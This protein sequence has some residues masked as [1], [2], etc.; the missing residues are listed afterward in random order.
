MMRL[1]G[2]RTSATTYANKRL[3]S[4]LRMQLQVSSAY[5]PRELVCRGRSLG[6]TACLESI[7]QKH[8]GLNQHL[9]LLRCW[10][11]SHRRPVTAG[12]ATRSG[13]P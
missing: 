11:M 9:M 12:A 3:S 1:A 7:S 10:S 5:L 6:P 4:S 13:S 8:I 2:V